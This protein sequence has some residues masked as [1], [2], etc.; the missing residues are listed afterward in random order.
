MHELVL[1]CLT[2]TTRKVLGLPRILQM[3]ERL[4]AEILE[5][6][7]PFV[8]EVLPEGLVK[9]VFSVGV[10]SGW[11]FVLKPTCETPPHFHPN[12]VQFTAV[13]E[14]SGR[15]RVGEEERDV[16]LFDETSFKPVWYVIGEGVP[17][18]VSTGGVPMVVV[19]FHTC[20]SGELLEVESES[21]R[22]RVYARMR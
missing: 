5:S 21:G 15:I 16:R 10:R 14:G 18:A 6:D 22:R 11:V 9:E 12:S 1:K 2:L 3:I 13:I 17:H 7:E 8:W 19:S 4:K 20:P